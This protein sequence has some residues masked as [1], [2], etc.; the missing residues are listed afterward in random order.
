MTLSLESRELEVGTRGRGLVD[1]TAEVQAFVRDCKV[2][3][4]L[5]TVFIHHTSASLL[6]TENADPEVHRDLERLFARLAPDGD[7]LFRHDAEGPDDMPAHVRSAL[8]Q[9]SLAIPVQAGRCALGT[10]QG[11]YLWEHRHAGH[12]RRLTLTV[13]GS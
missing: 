9:T 13:I 5:C 3:H 2:R 6:I 12:R 4:G 11:I 10:W 1:V 7:P 8:T